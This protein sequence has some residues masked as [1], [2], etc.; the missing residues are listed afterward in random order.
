MSSATVPLATSRHLLGDAGIHRLIQGR[1]GW[2]L[3]N[4]HDAYIGQAL[5]RYGEYGQIEAD[6]LAQLLR[7]GDVVIEVGANIGS[8][9]VGLAKTVGSTGRVIAFEPQRVVFQTL[10]ANIALNSLTWVDTVHAAVGLRAGSVVIGEPDYARPGNFGAVEV[11]SG[12]VTNGTASPVMLVTLDQM[13][14]GRQL[15]LI[16]VDV[17]GMEQDVLEGA[18]RLLT[19]LRPMLYVENDRRDRSAAL[20][21][22]IQSFGYVCYWHLPFLYNPDNW[23]GES[24]NVYPGTVSVNMLCL[25]EEVPS[26]ITGLSRVD[27]PEF[28]P[29]RH[30]K[31]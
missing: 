26:N 2:F 21:R 12:D 3:F 9:T 23:F 22:V 7:P 29:M 8:L 11:G 13:F 1:D 31:S 17:E 10:C 24:E 30:L 27:D 5:E 28:H 16:K 20:I 6:L 14:T 18:S 15:R 19:G 4:R 25:P